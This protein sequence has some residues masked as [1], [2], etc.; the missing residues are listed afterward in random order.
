M[1]RAHQDRL[2]NAHPSRPVRLPSGREFPM[3]L[4][5]YNCDMTIVSGKVDLEVLRE[6]LVGQNV[7][8]AILESLDGAK[9]GVAQIWL[10]DYKDANI[11]PYHEAMVSFSGARDATYT[12]SEVNFLSPL[13]AFADPRCMVLVNWLF[14][15]KDNAIDMG[16]EV[17]GFP[18][19]PADLTFQHTPVSSTET[20]LV[21]ETLLDGRPMLK[22]EFSLR[23]GLG[24]TLKA[25]TA[26]FPGMGTSTT[27]RMLTRRYHTA[28]AITP[29]RLKQVQA[30]VRYRGWVDVFPWGKDDRL[31]WI[32]GVPG[33]D[34]ADTMRRMKFEPTVVMRMPEVRFVM[35]T[36][37]PRVMQPLEQ[38]AKASGQD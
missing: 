34:C 32:P 18:K 7:Q 20:R 22:A 2:F 21:H 1:S 37:D 3:P 23:R 28:M 4:H 25:V 33:S 38:P 13:A 24:N 10:N 36:D 15:D 11:G 6:L 12:F 35:L 27:M 8:P 5:I 14:L 17:W 9:H 26:M 16:R 30:P 31:E 29:T 19:L